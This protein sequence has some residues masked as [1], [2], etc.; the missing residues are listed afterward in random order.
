MLQYRNYHQTLKTYFILHFGKKP[1]KLKKLS[2][3]VM[4]SQFGHRRITTLAYGRNSHLRS[5]SGKRLMFGIFLF[6]LIEC[7]KSEPYFFQS[8]FSSKIKDDSNVTAPVLGKLMSKDTLDRRSLDR[9]RRGDLKN[10]MC[11]D[12]SPEKDSFFNVVDAHNHFKPFNGPSVPFDTYFKWMQDAGILFSTMFGIG[13]KIEKK[14]PQ[15][16]M[17]Y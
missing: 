8:F 2:A 7:C 4:A 17:L 13:Q 12:R 15:G 9:F 1:R 10:Q 11:W 14:N 16:S 5:K 3:G 6:T